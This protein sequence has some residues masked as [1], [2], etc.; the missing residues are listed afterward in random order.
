MN[1][2]IYKAMHAI[3]SGNIAIGVVLIVIGVTVGTISII[4]GA[5]LLNEK[6]NIMI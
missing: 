4:T 6:K 1:E 5:K 3:G 2:K